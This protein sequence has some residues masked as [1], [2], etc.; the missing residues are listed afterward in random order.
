MAAFPHAFPAL[1]PRETQAWA[2]R[3]SQP[4][5]DDA[6]D[7]PVA[8]GAQ[9]VPIGDAP[10]AAGVQ[11]WTIRFA[12]MRFVLKVGRKRGHMIFK[13]HDNILKKSV[14]TV[15]LTDRIPQAIGIANRLVKLANYLWC[16]VISIH[17]NIP[18]SHFLSLSSIYDGWSV[19]RLMV[20]YGEWSG[21]GHHREKCGPASLKRILTQIARLLKTCRFNT[22]RLHLLKP[23]LQSLGVDVP[24]TFF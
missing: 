1:T 10:V 22:N 18:L 24:D 3:V 21:D 12:P 5:T 7:A 6:H 13:V 4:V 16:T 2:S 15:S 23:H 11:D 17:A 9:D 8:A 14:I 19:D 20:P